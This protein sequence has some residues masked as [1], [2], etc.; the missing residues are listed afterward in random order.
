[1]RK[2]SILLTSVGRRVELVEAFRNAALRLG[3]S[4]NVFGADISWSA[5]AMQFCDRAVNVPQISDSSYIP[6]LLSICKTEHI[7]ALIPTID[8]D[9]LLL[10]KHRAD[11]LAVGTVV[12]VAA[13]EKV[14][15][16]RDKRLTVN[17]FRS[18]GLHAPEA[19]DDIRAYT[20]GFPAFIKPLDGSSSIGADRADSEEE[21]ERLAAGLNGYIVQPFVKG[22][23][24]SVD[25][26]CGLEGNPIYIT[27]RQRLAVRSGEVLK[28]KIAHDPV[29]EQEILRLCKDFAPIGGITVQ[30]I[31]SITGV[32][33]YIEINPRFG[34]GAPLSMKAGADA[35]EAML[36]ILAGEQL[37]YHPN[38]AENGAIYSRF[39]QSVCVHRGESQPIQAVIFDLDDTLYNEKEY[40]K[41]GYRQVATVID[42]I[43]HGY[44]KL[45]SAFCEGRS[46]ID[47]VLQD[48]GIYSE[49]LKIKCLSAYRTHVPEIYL[50]EGV[51]DM[52]QELR[53]RGIKLGII[54]DGRPEGQR[55]K[56]K[57][58]KLDE[59]VD[60]IIVTD[61]LGGPQFRKPN[62]IAF[63]IM[64]GR[65]NVPYSAMLYVGDNAA[66]D[67]QAPKVLGMQWIH[68][69]NANG[70]YCEANSGAP[71]QAADTKEL[72]A[73]IN[74]LL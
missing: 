28:T 3:V 48:A 24:Y 30:F 29:T 49:E 18:L 20:G 64:Q 23:E 71:Y 39:D 66:K 1:M 58:L 37:Q 38:A 27:P 14:A 57:A 55:N 73:I 51:R 72:C 19:V 44:E 22:E 61:E 68:F 25:I 65:L 4:L 62:D 46:A 7:N 43:A 45:W 16:C 74:S 35:A 26:F 6:K 47:T 63:R 50:L 2:I 33:H 42:T 15:L 12:C 32:N 67:F 5:P 59:L 69:R 34:G 13:P 52:L 31:R 11:F 17:Y 8:T 41:S 53:D 70:I 54:T 36:R 40:I 10:A 60:S 21:L 9:L 56:L